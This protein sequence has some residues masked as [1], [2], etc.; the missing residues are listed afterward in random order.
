MNIYFILAAVFFSN[1]IL[2]IQGKSILLAAMM[3]LRSQQ[4]N[5]Q[6]VLAYNQ[7]INFSPS[8]F[9]FSDMLKRLTTTEKNNIR[10]TIQTDVNIERI[11]IINLEFFYENKKIL[12]GL[13]FEFKRGDKVLIFGASGSGKSTFLNLMCGAYQPSKGYINFLDK[14]LIQYSPT[15]LQ[16][17]YIDQ[18]YALFDDSVLNNITLWKQVDYETELSI[19]KL[20]K[21]FDLIVDLHQNVTELSG[22]QKQ[23]VVWIREL[24]QKPK[25]LFVDEGTSALDKE[26]SLKVI[27]YMLGREDLTVFLVSHDENHQKELFL[28]HI[29]L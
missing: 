6:L 4:Y 25:I 24:F 21:E 15:V 20:M 1:S 12:D 11:E 26:T 19:K 8:F 5:S 29:K 10:T 16:F 18:N 2:D 9:I 27:N 28:K 7:Y 23:R 14:N 13:N 3:V 22:G 17:G